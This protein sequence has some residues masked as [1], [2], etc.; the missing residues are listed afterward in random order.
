MYKKDD[1]VVFKVGGECFEYIV[2]K[3]SDNIWFLN[4]PD[5]CNSIIFRKLLIVDKFKFIRS[6]SKYVT[7][8]ESVAFPEIA[9]PNEI[10]IN[11]VI[12]ALLKKCDE[13]NKQL[14]NTTICYKDGDKIV[15]K[16]PDKEYNYR[17]VGDTIWLRW[18][19]SYDDHAGH[20]DQILNALNITDKIQF[21]RD[22]SGCDTISGQFPEICCPDST[23]I[24]KVINKLMIMCEEKMKESLK[25]EEKISTEITLQKPNISSLQS[26]FLDKLQLKYPIVTS[27][28]IQGITDSE[29][30]TMLEKS[31]PKYK[32][33][34]TN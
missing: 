25:T 15:F 10:E 14:N 3:K 24:T 11:K 19:L 12:D 31:I 4:I 8:D 16:L 22:V 7:V 29:T 9:Y 28:C 33:K 26:L 30:K 1:K 6:I 5:D 13:Y 32:L 27:N 18:Y 21:C 17:V 34:F 23:G 2:T 20:N